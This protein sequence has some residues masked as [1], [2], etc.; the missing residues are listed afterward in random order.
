MPEL[1]AHLHVWHQRGCE[2]VIVDGGSTDASLDLLAE[3]GLMVIVS[4][5][6]R[7]NQ[8]NAGARVARG[9]V[10]LFLHA[11]TRLPNSAIRLIETAIQLDYKWGR[12]DVNISGESPLFICIAY[13]MNIRS[14]LSG[15]ATGDQAIFVAREL[16]F[17]VKGY[18]IQPLMED[19]ELS[20][21]LKRMCSPYCIQEKV[22]TSGRRWQQHGVVRTVLLMWWLRFAYWLGVPINYLAKKYNEK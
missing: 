12:F 13:F 20:K 10:L 8:M 19:V 2:I 15:I 9:D 17:N 18:P 3:S 22:Q 21:R 16:F 11:D 7:A 6:G 1:I 4:D 14:R 5:R